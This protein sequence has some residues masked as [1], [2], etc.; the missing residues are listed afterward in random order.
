VSLD[1]ARPGLCSSEVRSCRREPAPVEY[2]IHDALA[3]RAGAGSQP[4]EIPPD[5]PNEMLVSDVIL[6]QRVQKLTEGSGTRRT[7][8]SWAS[9]CR[10]PM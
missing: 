4:L 2:V 8:S 10:I 3:N 6:I 5:A 9:F 1:D 7:R